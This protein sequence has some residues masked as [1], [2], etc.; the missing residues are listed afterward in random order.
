MFDALACKPCGMELIEL[1]HLLGAPTSSLLNL[2]RPMAVDGYVTLENLHYR[3]E[4][5]AFRLSAGIMSGW[6]L[7]DTLHA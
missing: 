3:Q 1:S 2:L 7:S 4:P 6:R 5:A